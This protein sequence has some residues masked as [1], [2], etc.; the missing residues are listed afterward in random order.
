MA[1]AWWG[2]DVFIRIMMPLYKLVASWG[3]PDG[4]SVINIRQTGGNRQQY[5]ELITAL[6]E[7]IRYNGH[8]VPQGAEIQSRTL[9]GYAFQIPVIT[10]GLLLSWPNITA[11]TRCLLLAATVPLVALASLLDIPFVLLGAFTDLTLH[12]HDPTVEPHQFFISWMRL[13]DDGG[14]IALGIALPLMVIAG[15]RWIAQHYFTR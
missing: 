6:T 3:T 14:R 10:F 11:T 15:Y 2:G 12:A 9:R 13:M 1:L 7:P 8:L 4:Y 5:I